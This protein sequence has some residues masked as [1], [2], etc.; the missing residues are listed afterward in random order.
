MKGHIRKR[1]E[2]SWSIVLDWGFHPGTGKRK[3]R[4]I[5]V[6]GAKR[7][8]ERRLRQV[9]SEMDGGVYVDPSRFSVSEYLDQWMRDYVPTAVSPRTAAGYR[10][11]V[12]RLKG[13]L[14]RVRLLGLKPLQVQGFYS[15]LLA[16]GFAR[17]TV[18]HHHRVFHNALAGAV[19]WGLLHGNVLDRVTPPRVNRPELRILTHP[20]VVSL[21]RE[22]SGTDSHVPIR[23][24]LF[25]GLRRSEICGLMWPDADLETR[26]L[27]VVRALV[28]VRGEPFRLAEPKSRGSRRTVSF[29][30][31]TADLLAEHRERLVERGFGDEQVCERPEGGRRMPDALSRGYCRIARR[32]GITGVRFHDLRHTHASVLLAGGV[33]VN[34]VRARMGHESVKTTVDTYGHLIPGSDALAGD[35]LEEKWSS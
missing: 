22:A 7:D 17:Q 20:E 33:P 29:G 24:A 16:E 21:L 15:D 32:C 34:V 5:S 27:T 23:L 14:G 8:A 4:W 10:T 28:P 30:G 31:S 9:L 6:K 18:M 2:R 3:Q 25:T 12:N 1:G 11:I 26:T 35:F 13:G 19:R